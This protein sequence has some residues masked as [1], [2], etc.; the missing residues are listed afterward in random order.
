MNQSELDTER[1]WLCHEGQKEHNDKNH[2]LKSSLSVNKSNFQ[3][4]V[5]VNVL[6]NFPNTIH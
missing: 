4:H 3:L 1:A 6:Y 5:S 2:R